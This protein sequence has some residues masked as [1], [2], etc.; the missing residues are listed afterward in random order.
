MSI[1]VIALSINFRIGSIV[2][3][4]LIMEGKYA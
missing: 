1:F 3:Y 4:N 2:S